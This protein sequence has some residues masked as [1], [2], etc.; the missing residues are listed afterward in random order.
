[1][2]AMTSP[3]AAFHP[4]NTLTYASLVAGM[5]ALFQA[6]DQNAAGA[7]ALIA[8]AVILDTFDGRFARLFARTPAQ[9]EIGVQLDSL[10]DAI[11]FGGVPVGCAWLL[12]DRGWELGLAGLLYATCAITRLAFYNVTHDDHD[13][14]VGLPVPVAALIWSTTLVLQPSA[15]AT[16]G[17]LAAAGCAMVLPFIV[18]RPRGVGLAAFACWPLIVFA[19]HVHRATGN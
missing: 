13:G 17:L 7:G 4:A 10:A 1:M 16:T 8:A 2:K 5:A 11:V 19:V 15:H 18:P 9:C 12:S 3:L 6:L 14:F